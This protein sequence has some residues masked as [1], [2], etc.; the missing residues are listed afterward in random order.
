MSLNG[1][2][3]EGVKSIMD[4]IFSALQALR[5]FAPEH[6]WQGL[7]NV[8]GDYGECIA[9]DHYN[10]KKA[11]GSSD[12]FD[13]YTK[14]GKTV[15]I[16]ANHAANQIGYRGKADLMLVLSIKDDGSWN[17]IYFGDFQTVLKYSKWSARDS[18]HTITISKLKKILKES[19][20]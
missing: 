12:G 20:D 8:L 19:S 17:E 18:K 16:K 10:L 9:I 6:R 3:I 13:A 11:P 7:G 4:T 2:K 15:Q 5:I 1:K 14:D